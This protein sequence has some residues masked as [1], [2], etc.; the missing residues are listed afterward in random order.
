MT[1]DLLETKNDTLVVL[2][3]NIQFK[4]QLRILF[5]AEKEELCVRV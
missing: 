4:I 2:Y 1:Q 5:T 3:F